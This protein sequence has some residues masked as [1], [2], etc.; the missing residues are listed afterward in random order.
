MK[1]NK[2]LLLKGLALKF[3]V[4]HGQVGWA[5]NDVSQLPSSHYCYVESIFLWQASYQQYVVLP[6][7]SIPFYDQIIL[8]DFNGFYKCI[9]GSRI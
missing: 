6:Q 9:I 3:L 2:I 4:I 5:E 8:E 1:A 7:Y